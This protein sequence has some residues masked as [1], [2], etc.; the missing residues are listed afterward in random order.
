[1]KFMLL[2]WVVFPNPA[3][4]SGPISRCWPTSNVLRE[5]HPHRQA[6]STSL[7]G[8]SLKVLSTLVVLFCT[9]ASSG[10]RLSR[11]A[12]HLSLL[13]EY[14]HP[15]LSI[16]HSGFWQAVLSRTSATS[17]PAES[18]G[19][20]SPVLR[21]IPGVDDQDL[22]KVSALWWYT[23][24]DA[25]PTVVGWQPSDYTSANEPNRASKTLNPTAHAVARWAPRQLTPS[26][27]YFEEPSG[28]VRI[29]GPLGESTPAS[30]VGFLTDRY[31]QPT[32]TLHGATASIDYVWDF[33]SSTLQVNNAGFSLVPSRQIQRQHLLM[34]AHQGC[35][36]VKEQFEKGDFPLLVRLNTAFGLLAANW[37][38]RV[39][40]EVRDSTASHLQYELDIHKDWLGKMFRISKSL[41][42]ALQHCYI[43]ADAPGDVA[44][45][46]GEIKII[47]AKLADIQEELRKHAA[48]EP[49]FNA[50]LRKALDLLMKYDISNI[51]TYIT[52][53]AEFRPGSLAQ[54][55]TQET[56]DILPVEMACKLL[57]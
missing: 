9:I 56:L 47:A 37:Q 23:A 11:S 8:L 5:F 42:A 25:F 7:S 44:A 39:P 34:L 46:N 6:L 49:P 55:L 53:S 30:L 28:L 2:F 32:R 54:L 31:G 57:Q 33:D 1:M 45:L 29:E 14:R 4:R 21:E 36:Q 48:S 43:L 41:D 35:D 40:Q 18:P 22:I 13:L 17:E 12:L 27:F 24:V 16:H 50:D 51:G 26:T 3:S 20:A 10:V 38:V 15:D 19:K 52:L